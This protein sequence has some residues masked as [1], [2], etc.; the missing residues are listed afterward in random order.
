[1]RDGQATIHTIWFRYVSFPYG[2]RTEIIV[3]LKSNEVVHTIRSVSVRLPYGFLSYVWD[4]S[5]RNL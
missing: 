2:F 4:T 1:M 5:G 3:T